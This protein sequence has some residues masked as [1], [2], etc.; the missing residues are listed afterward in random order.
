MIEIKNLTKRFDN[1]I[2]V[3]NLS[4]NIKPGING[5]VGEN[6]AGKSTLLRLIADIY[7][8]SE[9]EIL[10]DG[11]SNSSPK[12][13][14]NVFLL[15]DNPMHSFNGTVMSTMKM[16]AD[17][18]DLDKEK[19]NEIIEL[20]K[21][22]MKRRI[23]TFSKGMKR[24]LFLAIA[25]SMK[26]DYILMDEAF[27]GIDPIMQDIVKEQILKEAENKTF[28]ISSHNLLSLE[29]LC[30]NFILLSKGKLA[31]NGS[32][33]DMGTNFKKYQVLFSKEV[34]K[35]DIEK[36][37][38][39]IISFRT[40]GS[41][42]HIVFE[43]KD[44]IDEEKIKKVFKPTLFEDVPLDDDEVFKLEMLVSRREEN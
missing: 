44:N 40:I 32:L 43:T 1:V 14:K 16:Y 36:E 2:A 22:P 35:E 19:F 34:S 8:K 25:L 27:D 4:I 3:N 20:L 6:G 21:L 29:R 28:I 5:L 24:Q 26:A 11:K 23:S 30:D 39:K 17:L 7:S 13:K 41:I 33:D 12:V 18:F 38:Y 10:I 42:C 37:G 9:G 31:K 15:S